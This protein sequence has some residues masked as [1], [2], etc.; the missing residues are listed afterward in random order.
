MF[1]DLIYLDN[2]VIDPFDIELSRI[3]KLSE[4]VPF[5][6]VKIPRTAYNAKEDIN[7]PYN[8]HY[9][10]TGTTCKEAVDEANTEFGGYGIPEGRFDPEWIS[11]IYA[12]KGDE[13]IVNPNPDTVKGFNFWVAEGLLG[14]YYKDNTDRDYPQIKTLRKQGQKL[15]DNLIHNPSFNP[16]ESE[17]DLIEL[18]TDP[19]VPCF[20]KLT[21][22]Y[23]DEIETFNAA[24]GECP[25]GIKIMNYGSIW[26]SHS[27]FFKDPD[28]CEWYQLANKDIIP[29]GDELFTKK[30]FGKVLKPRTVMRG[31]IQSFR[32][33]DKVLVERGYLYY[34]GT[35]RDIFLKLEKE[36]IEFEEG[37]I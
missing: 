8:F 36:G 24:K 12:F 10:R 26:E 30:F 25:S 19:K 20:I 28:S 11:G 32:E 15:Y 14:E 16:K 1:K 34:D 5:T 23:L 22:E 2:M 21:P 31:A 13:I 7:I 6:V 35:L 9:L 37:I 3:H 17:Y 4:E 29:E 33:Q 18:L 27:T